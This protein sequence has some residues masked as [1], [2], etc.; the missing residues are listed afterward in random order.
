[1]IVVTG[2]YGFIA[3]CLVRHLNDLGHRDIVVVD[4]FYKDRKEPNLSG[5]SIREWIH[6]DIFQAW[7]EKNAKYVDLV[8]H[9][10]ARTDTTSKDKAVFDALNLHFSQQL[11]H[12]CVRSGVSLVYASSAATYGD[13]VHGYK[14]DQTLLPALKPMNAYAESKHAFDLWALA[15]P[16]SPPNWAGLKFFNVYGPNE[17]HKGRMAS[18]VWHGY[19]QIHETG[20]LKLF[21]SHRK[22]IGHGEQQ[23]DFIY[24]KD[25]I[26][27][28]TFF[29]KAE[30]PNGIY[31]VGTG[32]ARS[33]L[34][35]G[36]ALFTAL[37]LEPNIEFIPTPE[38]IRDTYQYYTQAE[39]QKLRDAG[40]QK[41]FTD[42]EHGV[43]DYVQNYLVSTVYY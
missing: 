7:F 26:D 37:D 19:R 42:L 14:D 18:V 36:N 20:L 12:T 30:C 25:V 10:G 27:V 39:M 31:N 16:Q 17:Y 23:R 2:A 11:W 22:G 29:M 33:F 28:C 35:L 13:G 5:K 43:T 21:Q 8:F 9:L 1:M 34:D 15:Q 38:N 24:V 4:D 3:S 6:R 32:Q 41:S 40:Y